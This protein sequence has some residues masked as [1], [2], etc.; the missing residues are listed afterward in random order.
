MQELGPGKLCKI[1]QIFQNLSRLVS[2]SII[3]NKR[4]WFQFDFTFKDLGNQP[5][6]IDVN[7]MKESLILSFKQLQ[8]MKAA[9]SSCE[10]GP[11]EDVQ[12][13]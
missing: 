8:K 9:I 3:N 13:E 5:P 2:S 1:K 11:K 4:C 7:A 12:C 10:M 6:S